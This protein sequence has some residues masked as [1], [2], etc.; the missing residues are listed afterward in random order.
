LKNCKKLD[1]YGSNK[2]KNWPCL[3]SCLHRCGG[4]GWRRW[5]TLEAAAGEADGSE[6]GDGVRSP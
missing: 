4:R 3:V 1:I 2:D 5:W 6:A